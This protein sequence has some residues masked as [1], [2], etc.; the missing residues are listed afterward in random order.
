METE[1]KLRRARDGIESFLDGRFA[2]FDG[3]KRLAAIVETIEASRA[4]P[5]P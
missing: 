1:G 2:S 4:A 5:L 3:C